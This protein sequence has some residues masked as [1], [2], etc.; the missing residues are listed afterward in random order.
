MNHQTLFLEL[1]SYSNL[2]IFAS[3]I[4]NDKC[5]VVEG[6][7]KRHFEDNFFLLVEEM[8]ILK[9]EVDDL[10]NSNFR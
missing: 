3:Q 5:W 9:D 7:R 10:K 8:K 4:M 2:K 1:Y 6:G